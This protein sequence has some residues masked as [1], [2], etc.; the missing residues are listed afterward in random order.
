MLLNTK[1]LGGL[2]F[3]FFS[4]VF[5]KFCRNSFWRWLEVEPRLWRQRC[6]SFGRTVV[7]SERPSYPQL[8]SDILTGSVH[9][10]LVIA[11]FYYFFYYKWKS[12]AQ[13]HTKILMSHA[14]VTFLAVFIDVMLKFGEA[15]G[16]S[17]FSIT[18]FFFFSSLAWV[19]GRRGGP[20][21]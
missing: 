15:Y 14:Q 9:L 17:C 13:D 20:M 7:W 5:Q 18:F 10:Q 4:S 11:F 6:L 12:Q 2:F 1:L 21:G 16:C 19:H 8:I 3:C